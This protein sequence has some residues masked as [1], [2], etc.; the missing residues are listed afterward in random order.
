ME[1]FGSNETSLKICGVTIRSEAEKLAEMGV[2]AVGFNFWPSSKR[3]LDPRANSWMKE[4]AGGILRV[5][6]FVNESSDLPFRLYE[7]GMID[8]VQL[9][10]NEPPECVCGFRKAGI[11]VVKALGVK[12]HSD[13]EAAEAYGADAILLDAHAPQSFGGTGETFDWSL[14][15]GFKS[16]FSTIPMILAGGIT[17][18]NATEAIAVVRPTALDVASGAECSP[19]RKDFGKVAALLAACHAE[20]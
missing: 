9:H 4:L 6:V 16:R 2:H 15:V 5:G 19:G 3:Y 18:D 14:A 10:G 7:E 8:V 1:L 11:P 13:L 12:D 20:R 17:A